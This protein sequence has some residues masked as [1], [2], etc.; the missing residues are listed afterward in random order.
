MAL[1]VENRS[2]IPEETAEIGEAFRKGEIADAREDHVQDLISPEFDYAGRG[3][4]GKV[5]V[6]WTQ[7]TMS[8]LLVLLCVA[9]PNPQ[10]AGSWEAPAQRYI[11]QMRAQCLACAKPLHAAVRRIPQRRV[12]F[13]SSESSPESRPAPDRARLP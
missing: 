1:I 7:R 11:T 8:S 12:L 2:A 3:S 10:A 9:V 6:N 5:G 4:C 13:L